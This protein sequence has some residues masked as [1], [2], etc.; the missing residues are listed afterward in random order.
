MFS[1]RADED[2][3]WYKTSTIP[4]LRTGLFARR[5]NCRDIRRWTNLVNII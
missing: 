4:I 2:G 5:M 1:R 3:P